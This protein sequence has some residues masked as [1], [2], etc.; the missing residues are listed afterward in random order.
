MDSSSKIILEKIIT[1][2]NEDRERKEEENKFWKPE[3]E[4]ERK[5][6]EKYLENI[7]ENNPKTKCP[8]SPPLSVEE[9]KILSDPEIVIKNERLN[10]QWLIK[11]TL[12][13]IIKIR[14]SYS[15]N[16]SIKKIFCAMKR[17][18]EIQE[19]FREV[20]QKEIIYE[21]EGKVIEKK[22]VDNKKNVNYILSKNGIGKEQIKEAADKLA[23]SFRER[24]DELFKKIESETDLF[25]WE[26]E[27]QGVYKRRGGYWFY[28]HHFSNSKKYQQLRKFIN[29]KLVNDMKTNPDNWRLTIQLNFFTILKGCSGIFVEKLKPLTNE[30]EGSYALLHTFTSRQLTQIGWNLVVKKNTIIFYPIFAAIL[31]SPLVFFCIWLTKKKKKDKKVLNS[32]STC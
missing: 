12:S 24:E 29:Q 5:E 9:R 19:N 14:Y 21:M 10:S 18:K 30:K 32:K 25:Q 6:V 26:V 2:F 4:E 15:E 7:L 17:L 20:Y 3:R 27:S 28:S 13:A 22:V 16:V 23:Q 8:W 31:V 1:G 11:L